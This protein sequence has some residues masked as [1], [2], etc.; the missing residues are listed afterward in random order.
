MVPFA[1]EKISE[2]IA[3]HMFDTFAPL[4]CGVKSILR[5]DQCGLPIL[6]ISVSFSLSC[7]PPTKSLTLSFRHAFSGMETED[8]AKWYCHETIR[9]VF[10]EIAM[11]SREFASQD[12]NMKACRKIIK[13]S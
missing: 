3:A 12:A 11:A 5:Q 4:G 10:D 9:Q 8:W 7:G 6:S 13:E 1:T 2:K